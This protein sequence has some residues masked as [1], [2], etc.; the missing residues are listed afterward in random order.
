MNAFK[1]NYKLSWH[2][3]AA[4]AKAFQSSAR[5]RHNLLLAALSSDRQ[6]DPIELSLFSL[7]TFADSRHS[8]PGSLSSRSSLTSAEGL[9]QMV[10]RSSSVSWRGEGGKEKPHFPTFELSDELKPWGVTCGPGGRGRDN[11]CCGSSQMA[12]RRYIGAIRKGESRRRLIILVS[13]G[14]GRLRALAK[15]PLR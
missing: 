11:C 4:T 3:V 7:T 5:L 14:D 2:L 8:F 10:D 6:S 1:L 15:N 9:K 12:R 13:Q